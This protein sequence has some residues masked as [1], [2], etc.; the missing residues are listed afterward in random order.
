MC[1]TISTFAMLKQCAPLVPEVAARTKMLPLSASSPKYSLPFS[2]SSASSAHATVDLHDDRFN[3]EHRDNDRDQ[4]H[5]PMEGAAETQAVAE[6]ED[7]RFENDKLGPEQDQPSS[8]EAH[9][10]RKASLS[11]IEE[12]GNPMFQDDRELQEDLQQHGG[13]QGDR[14]RVGGNVLRP[15]FNEQVQHREIHQDCGEVAHEYPLPRRGR[16][17]KGL[18]ERDAS[19]CCHLLS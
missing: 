1:W 10:S 6:C 11:R 15:V 18:P 17:L 3:H 8:E 7:E 16:V 5:D 12:G 9:E 13:E 4:G 14:E 19:R 2:D